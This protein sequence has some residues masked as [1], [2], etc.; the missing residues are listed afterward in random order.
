MLEHFSELDRR[1]RRVRLARKVIL[2][3]AAGIASAGILLPPL[4]GAALAAG[5]ALLVVVAFLGRIERRISDRM[6]VEG[7]RA[8][9]ESGFD[10]EASD[11]HIAALLEERRRTGRTALQ[12]LE[13]RLG[14][15]L[16][17]YGDHDKGG[18]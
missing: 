5:V 16:P 3:L 8:L 17:R 12:Q 13:Q 1:Q 7:D 18:R 2:I 4:A 14:T 10:L 9:V 6:N 15:R 11:R